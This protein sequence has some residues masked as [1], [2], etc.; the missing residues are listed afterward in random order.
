MRCRYPIQLDKVDDNGKHYSIYVPCGKCAWCLSAFRNE[1]FFRLKIESRYHLYSTFM[2]YTYDDDHLPVNVHEETGVVVPSVRKIDIQ[3]FHHDLQMDKYKFR[4]LVTSEYGPKTLRPH[5]H[6]VYFHDDPIPFAELWPY[7]ENN[8]QLP[9][10]DSSYKYILKYVLKGSHV[11]EGADPNFRLMSRRPK[12]LGFQFEYKGTPYI[13]TENGVKVSAPSYYKRVYLNS[14][15]DKLR[16]VI[17]CM[18]LDY[19]SSKDRLSEL[20]AIYLRDGPTISF[21]EWLDKLYERDY[22]KQL[23]INS[24]DVNI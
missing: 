19:L 3:K 5:Y 4:Y 20:N 16:E 8:V 15:N 22:Y 10:K 13:L 12:G 1:W 6:G 9:A 11:P 2:T 24:K 17:K 14:L 21:E 18:K 7:G 23:K